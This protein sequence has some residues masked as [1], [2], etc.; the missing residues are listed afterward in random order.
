MSNL[1]PI[2][3]RPHE[4]D[5]LE[6]RYVVNRA[7]PAESF[8][9]MKLSRQSEEVTLRFWQP[10]NLSIE[11]G[12]PR[13]TRGMVFYDRRGEWLE[14]IGIEVADFEASP[15]SILFSARSVERLA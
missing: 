14:N 15:G 8:I 9:D 4:Y 3:E 10:V 7:A 11:A 12:F 5:L 1:H 13:P 6:F 2:L